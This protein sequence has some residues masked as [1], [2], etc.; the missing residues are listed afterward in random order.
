MK[1]VFDFPDITLS[2]QDLRDMECLFS[3]AMWEFVKG[4][5]QNAHEYVN[6]RYPLIDGV[7]SAYPAGPRRDAKILEV[8][9]RTELASR[10]LGYLQSPKVE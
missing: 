5:R 1:L 10:F 2:E 8:E 9:R 7:H 4:A 3:D 6:R